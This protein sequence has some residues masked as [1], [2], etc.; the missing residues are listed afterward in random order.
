ML[1][2]WVFFENA[3][4]VSTKAYS[5]VRD[6]GVRCVHGEEGGNRRATLLFFEIYFS[7]FAENPFAF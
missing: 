6:L 1:L 2:F 5:T 3:F 7:G 4:Q